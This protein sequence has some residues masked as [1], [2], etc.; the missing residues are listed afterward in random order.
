MLDVL[1]GVDQQLFLFINH[2]PHPEIL[3]FLAKLISGSQ[4][5]GLIWFVIAFLLIYFERHHPKLL[6]QLTI[7]LIGA[8]YTAQG[9]IKQLVLRLRPELVLPSA[10]V[11]TNTSDYLS[12]PSSHAATAF[13]AATVLSTIYPRGKIGLFS[14]A[15]LV[16]FSRV[17]LGVHYSLDIIGGGLIGLGIGLIVVK[18]TRTTLV[19]KKI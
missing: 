14:L 1:K 13:A 3:V 8:S 19:K 15:A 6:L 16:A 18:L 2:L 9:F 12:F 17:Y 5:L 4:S 7:A 10:V 11:Y